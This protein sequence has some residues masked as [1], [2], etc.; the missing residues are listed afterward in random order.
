MATLQKMASIDAQMR[1]L[2]P[3]RVSPDDKLIEYDALLLDRFLD[4]LEDLHG[5]ELK[6]TV[7]FIV[8]SPPLRPGRDCAFLEFFATWDLGGDVA[9]F[10]FGILDREPSTRVF[11]P[12]K[13]LNSFTTNPS[14]RPAEVFLRDWKT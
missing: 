5:K 11:D 14:V 2:V 10:C 3:K 1:L 12:P 4:I 7:Q 9:T 13:A 8:P 6:D